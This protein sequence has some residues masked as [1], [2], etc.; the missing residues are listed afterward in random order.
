[1]NFL[2]DVNA[3][4][5]IARW[6]IQR[7]HDVAEVGHKDPRM[8][9]DEILKWAVRERRIL[10]LSKDEHTKDNH[11]AKNPHNRR[12]RLYRLPPCATPACPG[13]T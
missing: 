10:S 8:S 5:V 2:L 9:D 11:H 3:S 7:G 1:M 6:L 13:W 4:G 12:R